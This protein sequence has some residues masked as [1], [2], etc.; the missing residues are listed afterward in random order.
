MNSGNRICILL[1]AI[2][3][4]TAAAATESRQV[5]RV[6]EDAGAPVARLMQN[7]PADFPRFEFAG[8][9]QQ[10][11]LLTH[12]LWYHFHHRPGNGLTLF[13]KEYLLT[14]DIWLGNARPRGSDR[15]I[16]EVHRSLLL[17]MQMDDEGYVLTHQHFSHAHDHG[18]PFPLWTQSDNHPDRVKG[19][20]FGWH[21]QPLDKVP[22]WAGGHLRRWKR[23][24]YAGEKATA[25]WER[26]N[27]RSLGMENNRWQLETT[28]PSPT[29]I[30]PA[31]YSIEA[32]QSPYLQLRWRRQGEPKNHALPYVEWLREGDSEFD[33]D[34]RVHFR[35]EKTPL[36]R[37]CHHSIIT[38]HR[39]PKWTGRIERI[40][41]CLGPGESSGRFEID[42]FF[43][44]YDTRHTIN[45]PIFI[46]ASARYFNWTGDLDFLRQQINRMRLALRY[47]QTVMGG[48]EHK[49][50]RNSWP[51]HDG[52]PGFVR[53]PD[54]K[55]TVRG[56]HGI[57]NNYWDLM[58]F[59][60]DDLYATSQYHA[61]T[62]AMAD[63]ERA[64]EDNPG[65]G[66]PLGAL[67]L[68]PGPLRGHAAEVR[69][70]A[71]ELFWN[72]DTGRFFASIDK[73]GRRY[74]YGYTFLNLDAIWYGLPSEDHARSIMDWIA[75][76]RIV[77]GDTSQGEDIYHWRFGPRA[78]T[79]RNV[80][81]YGQGWHGPESIPW[82]GQV[83]DGGAVLGF[84]FYD[85]WARLKDLGPD[86]CWQRLVEILA[87]EKDVHSE[88][89]YRKYYEGGKRGTT[90]Q[91]GGTAG[92]LG[93]DHEFYESSLLPSIVVYGFL[94]LEADPSGVLHIRPQLP[95]SCPRMGLRNIL[96]HGLRLDV[97]A[98]EER[99]E[100]TLKDPPIDPVQVV[101]E[102]AWKEETRDQAG[103]VFSLPDVGT[104]RFRRNR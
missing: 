97:A 33:V 45:N 42:S 27:L 55:V 57:G 95:K 49:H 58:P 6:A 59:G 67:R 4:L 92:G 21:F 61:A 56:G 104:Y 12:Y 19:K 64:I 30:T 50:I 11:D 18:W 2:L 26:H 48:L 52:L 22:G 94:G 62:L 13:N 43:T 63:L 103:P 85:L 77:R 81:W 23:D 83:Q 40:R 73:E 28:G 8:H 69:R 15:P 76:R 35:P 5:D 37:D 72:S 54:G 75:G 66:M 102:G 44:V 101:L 65:W 84:S 46:L 3:L 14:S 9:A 34:R 38:M 16:Q 53:D 1:L 78:T 99:I 96:Y 86:D 10:A 31:G 100:I 93:I 29:L 17:G 32:F 68:A 74:D 91:G 71:N 41:I 70:V 82:G 24:E 60:W 79:M 98:T 36:S 47:Q 80:D 88:G 87:W 51:G 90:L 89:G 39:H 20:T 25:L 7:I